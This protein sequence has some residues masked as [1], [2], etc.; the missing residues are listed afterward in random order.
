MNDLL[1]NF[2]QAFTEVLKFKMI[3]FIRVYHRN[4]FSNLIIPKLWQMDDFSK[5]IIFY[6]NKPLHQQEIPREGPTPVITT[7]YNL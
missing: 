1:R 6:S 7:P 5:K 4:I 2:Q 3:K